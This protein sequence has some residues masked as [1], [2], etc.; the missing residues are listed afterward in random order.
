MASASSELSRGAYVSV[1]DV[2]V[3]LSVTERFVRRLIADGELPAV[4]IGG[5]L[6]RVRRADIDRILQPVL[7][8][9]S[10]TGN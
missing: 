1:A 10:S 8:L 5:R 9:G 7:S 2:A 3:E 4:K 6:V